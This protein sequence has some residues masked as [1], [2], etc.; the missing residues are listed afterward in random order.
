MKLQEFISTKLIPIASKIV[1]NK[2]LIS[3]RNGFAFSMSFLIV[4]SFILLLV[5]LPLNDPNTFL[6]QQWYVNIINKY[7]ENLIQPFYV[8]LGIMSIFVVFGIGHSLSKE[9]KISG[10]TGGFLSI[11]TFLIL[12]GQSDII[13]YGGDTIKWAIPPGSLFPVIDARYLGAQGIF[14]GI[15][16]AIFSVET[17]RFL[18]Y[19]KVTLK[20]PNSVPPAIAKSFEALIPVIVLTIIAQSI[21]ILVQNTTNNLLPEIMTNIFKPIL[22]VSDTLLGTLV[23]VFIIQILWFFGIHGSHI[24][25]VIL[26]PIILTNLEINTRAF[27]ENLPIP[28]ILA[29]E[30]LNG[31]AFIGGCGATLG[32][33]IPMLTSK[34]Q[35][36]KT[37]GKLSLIPGIFNINEPITFGCPIVLNPILGIPFI[38]V[39]L[40]NTTIAY[41]LTNFGFIEKTKV[42]I[43]WTT[44]GPLSAFISTGLDPRAFILSLLLLVLSTI[45]YLPFLRAY[46]KVISKQEQESQ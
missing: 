18:I 40:I 32:L 22:Y 41:T 6:Y 43:P 30:F 4:G 10:T 14:T 39:P 46:E 1:S 42:L 7:K 8:S 13:I 5:N 16:A 24:I 33:A 9:Y 36:L 17:Y 2:Y 27:S 3:L 15:L 11:F 19:K 34:V 44:P 20:L 31:F 35:H 25:G 23:I 45:I 12:C 38:L 37:I 29:G 26:Q 21:N 28:H